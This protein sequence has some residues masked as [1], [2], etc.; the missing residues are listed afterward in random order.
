[1]EHGLRVFSTDDCMVAHA[2]RSKHADAPMLRAFLTMDMDERWVE[3]PPSVLFE[4]FHWFRG[5]GFGL[6]LDDLLCLP[7]DPPILVEGFRLLPRLV[8]PLLSQPRQAVWLVP[9]LEFRRHA[10][11]SRGT[12]W[13]P[14]ETSDPNKALAN[15]LERDQLFTD[16]VVKEAA[17]LQLHVI[18][19]DGTLNV[20]EVTRRVGESLGLP[21]A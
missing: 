11:A 3:R 19:V 10:F 13:F 1:V 16:Q 21:S 7:K 2:R 18:E 12:A 8:A 6:I 17:S 5:E 9:S 15:L 4:T 14:Y 20:D